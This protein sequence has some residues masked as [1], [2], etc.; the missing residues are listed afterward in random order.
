MLIFYLNKARIKA[1][2]IIKVGIPTMIK[3]AMA[4]P[5]LGLSAFLWPINPMI[6]KTTPTKA[7]IAARAAKV[8]NPASPILLAAMKKPSTRSIGELTIIEKPKILKVA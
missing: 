2:S 8:L 7:K 1:K 6:Q 4:K 5:I 3:P